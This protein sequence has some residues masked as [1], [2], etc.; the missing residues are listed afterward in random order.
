MSNSASRAARAASRATPRAAAIDALLD[1]I[2]HLPVA[3]AASRLVTCIDRYA[4]ESYRTGLAVGV[5][6]MFAL[7]GT[8]IRNE[9]D[10]QTF[11]GAALTLAHGASEVSA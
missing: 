10:S 8:F 2:L 9:I 4:D 7:T 11:V 5:E 6:A 1:R 3:D